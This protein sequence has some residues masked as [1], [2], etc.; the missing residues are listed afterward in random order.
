VW[1]E[2]LVKIMQSLP[3]GSLMVDSDLIVKKLLSQ[4]KAQTGFCVL[5]IVGTLVAMDCNSFSDYLALDKRS[6]WISVQA[7]GSAIS[8]FLDADLI[9]WDDLSE[10][11][12]EDICS[13][14]LDQTND[15][16]DIFANGGH[17]DDIYLNAAFGFS[18]NL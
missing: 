2:M 17:Y 9:V 18:H 15:V 12:Q 13:S 6:I 1:H 11:E 7:F 14:Y 5:F 8:N 16:E 3:G 4:T 10:K